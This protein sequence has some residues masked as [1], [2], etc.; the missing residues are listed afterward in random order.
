MKLT[1]EQQAIVNQ[2]SAIY[3][4][5]SG[6]SAA[7]AVDAMDADTIGRVVDGLRTMCDV[8]PLAD[9]LELIIAQL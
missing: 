5:A 6:M 8:S 3:A 1:S 4:Q 9:E 2:A 7:A